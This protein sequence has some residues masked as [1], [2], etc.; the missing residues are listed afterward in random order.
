VFCAHCGTEI[1]E[2]S[3]FCAKCGHALTAAPKPET[4]S[5][6]AGRTASRNPFLT[7]VVV[8]L[9]VIVLLVLG[10]IVAH[11][12]STRFPKEASTPEVHPQPRQET[13][14]NTA[15]TVKAGQY[16]YYKFPVPPDATNVW[17]DGN[18]TASGGS[19]ND[20]E[21][22]LFD[23]DAF[24][25]WQNHHSVRAYYNSGRAT[26]EKIYAGLPPRAGTYYLIFSNTFSL[27]TPKA[28]QA[29]AILH[30]TN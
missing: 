16:V 11:R 2:G 5:Y 18:F 3:R 9:G 14:T 6:K 27:I 12:S 17:I 23:E 7:I 20:V 30:Y 28:L 29:S 25:N 13:V 26:Q 8:G 19:G 21:V 15:F 24:V 22:Y 4:T 10:G 1:P